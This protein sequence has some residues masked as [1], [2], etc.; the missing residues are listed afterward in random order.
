VE[1]RSLYVPIKGDFILTRNSSTT[2]REILAVFSENL[3]QLSEAEPSKTELCRKLGINRNQFNRYLSGQ[4]S[5]RPLQ[6]HR[7]CEYF[8]VDARILLEPLKNAKDQD[9]SKEPIKFGSSLCKAFQPVSKAVLPDGLYSEWKYSMIHPGK[10]SFGLLRIYTENGIRRVRS[11]YA[12]RLHPGIISKRHDKAFSEILGVAFTQGSGFAILDQSDLSNLFALA[13]FR[14]GHYYNPDLFPGIEVT[15]SS[16]QLAS[17]GPIFLERLPSETG[18]L[19]AV[20]RTPSILTAA[21]APEHVIEIL[22]DI[23]KQGFIAE[24]SPDNTGR[25]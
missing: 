10:I 9:Q 14:V 7:I 6:L 20:A 13:S 3:R 1:Y 15:G 11:K 17:G 24:L 18:P 25:T 21:E 8:Q 12:L 22:H 5:P 4:A 16:H 19:L 23:A 2:D